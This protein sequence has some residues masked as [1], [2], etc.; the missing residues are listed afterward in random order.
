MDFGSLAQAGG[1]LGSGTMLVMDESTCVVDF[2]RA[3]AVFFAHES[4]GQCTPCREGTHR[5]LDVLIRIS[6]GRGRSQDLDFLE[7]LAA[8]LMDASFCPLGQ[9]APVPLLSALKNFRL[10]IEE[11]IQKKTCRAGVCRLA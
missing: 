7:H 3:V 8:V 5:L 9:S 6:R 1:A 11:H 2:L 4:C 10:E